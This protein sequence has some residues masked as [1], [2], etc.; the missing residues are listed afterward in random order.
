MKQ[1]KLR[2]QENSKSAPLPLSLL[3]ER[4]PLLQQ[5]P[6]QLQPTKGSIRCERIKEIKQK[7]QRKSMSMRSRHRSALLHQIF[8]VSQRKQ[9]KLKHLR[10]HLRDSRERC[11]N[12]LKEWTR[13]VKRKNASRK[14]QNVAS[15]KATARTF[16]L[17]KLISCQFPQTLRP[18]SL[19]LNNHLFLSV[20]RS[21]LVVSSLSHFP[22][23][24]ERRKWLKS[25]KEAVHNLSLPR[26][27]WCSHN[28]RQLV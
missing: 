28:P 18:N 25:C 13:L 7:K 12:S 19:D 26:V 11:K 20:R 10:R 3:R 9:R 21:I 2:M 14:W 27:V 17:L 5:L 1:R 15:Q 23:L 8:H 24:S 6:N 22:I 16:L 4:Q